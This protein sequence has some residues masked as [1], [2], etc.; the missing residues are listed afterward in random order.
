MAPPPRGFRVL[1]KLRWV[2]RREWLLSFETVIKGFI[3]ET[4]PKLNIERH[5][6]T[7]QMD[8]VRTGEAYLRR[9]LEITQCFHGIVKKFSLAENRICC[10]CAGERLCLEKKVEREVRHKSWDACAH[11]APFHW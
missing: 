4:V 5:I 2:Q 7:P 11:C 8:W 9:M 1:S 6:G 10:W 3:K